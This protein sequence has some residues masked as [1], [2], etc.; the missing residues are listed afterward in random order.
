MPYTLSPSNRA[1]LRAK[2]V[3][4]SQKYKTKLM[5]KIFCVICE[6][7][8]EYNVRFFSKDFIHLTGVAS[9]LDDERF[10]E[11]SVKGLLT[12]GNILENQKYNWS[13]LKGKSDRIENIDQVIYGDSE[14]SLFIINLHTNTSDYPTAIANKSINTCI[15]FRSEL[16][17]ARTLRKYSN[18]MNADEKKEIIA[19]FSKIP[20]KDE[21]S[22]FVYMKDN[23]LLLEKKADIVSRLSED[24]KTMI[25]P[26]L[27]EAAATITEEMDD[28][29]PSLF[30]F[31]AVADKRPSSISF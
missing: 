5:G 21:Y 16:N 12:D 7:A 10:F 23:R 24:L 20:G 25:L 31:N 1:R 26:S 3:T 30:M 27:K 6:D 14:N 29:T 18:S 11:N 28:E 22:E 2:I 9:D 4:G 19:I 13:T 8:S 17:R 15:G